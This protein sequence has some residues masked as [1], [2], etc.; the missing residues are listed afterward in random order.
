MSI[1]ITIE[2]KGRPSELRDVLV[3]E[4]LDRAES[5]TDHAPSGKATLKQ[6]RDADKAAALRA[7]AGWMQRIEFPIEEARGRSA[8]LY[9]GDDRETP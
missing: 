6:V 7:F 5:Y 1:T 8:Y 4:A 3:K 9:E 2:F